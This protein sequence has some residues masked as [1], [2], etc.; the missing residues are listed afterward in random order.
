MAVIQKQPVLYIGPNRRYKVFNCEVYGKH[1][2]D[3]KGF[4]AW[5]LLPR[6][7]VPIIK[8][9]KVIAEALIVTE[10]SELPID[11]AGRYDYEAPETLT[12]MDGLASLQNLASNQTGRDEPNWIILAIILLA[13]VIGV[14]AIVAMIT[15]FF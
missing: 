5:H 15:H 4:R 6:F 14:I 1:A 2:I 12:C 13:I 8:G 11:P 3:H 9:K 7:I 10:A